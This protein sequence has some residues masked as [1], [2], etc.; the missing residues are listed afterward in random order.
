MGT[1]LPS[2]RTLR[3][4]PVFPRSIRRLTPLSPQ[5]GFCL[6]DTIKIAY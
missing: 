1:P 2:V 5:G 3:L 6:Q 4:V